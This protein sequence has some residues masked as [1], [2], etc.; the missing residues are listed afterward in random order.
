MIADI[1]FLSP[2]GLSKPTGYSHVV[3]AS[4]GTTVY[5]SGQVAF[6]AA[7]KVVGEVEAIALIP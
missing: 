4:G 1:R 6:D 2:A 3:V 5:I 7:G